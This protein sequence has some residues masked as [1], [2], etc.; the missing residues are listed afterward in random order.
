M[1]IIYL[2][3]VY[4]VVDGDGKYLSDHIDK[5]QKLFDVLQQVQFSS[6]IQQTCSYNNL[7]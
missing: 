1:K 3:L 4:F 5:E 2:V 6:L 7:L